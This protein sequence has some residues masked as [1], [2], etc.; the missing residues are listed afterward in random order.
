MCVLAV[1][2]YISCR[3]ESKISGSLFQFVGPFFF[4]FL[5]NF[6]FL[7]F[8][9]RVPAA[10]QM[11]SGPAALRPAHSGADLRPPLDEGSG[12]ITQVTG[13]ACGQRH[14]PQDHR[15]RFFIKH[16]LEQGEPLREALIDFFCWGGGAKKQIRL[17]GKRRGGDRTDLQPDPLTQQARQE[18]CTLIFLFC[19]EFLIYY[20]CVL[21]IL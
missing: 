6:F 1:I 18:K 21:F 8:S 15:H 13:G 14:P 7:V 4:F 9:S 16:K 5:T 12:R 17:C 10:D 2:V 11:V 20:L 3:D 19:R